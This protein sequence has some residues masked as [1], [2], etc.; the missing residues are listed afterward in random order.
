MRLR[1]AGQVYALCGTPRTL[2]DE[3]LAVDMRRCQRCVAGSTP[4]GCTVHGCWYTQETRNQRS[5]GP[6][7]SACL[8]A[9]RVRVLPSKQVAR[10]RVPLEAPRVVGGT[11][12]RRFAKPRHLMVSRFNSCTTR[13]AA[14]IRA[15]C[16]RQWTRWRWA[17]RVVA[18]NGPQ[19]ASNTGP[20]AR[21]R[22]RVLHCPPC[23][24]R[25]RQGH[26]PCKR[27]NAGPLPV[28]GPYAL[29]LGVEA[30]G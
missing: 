25:P 27:E 18:R 4:A 3:V 11:V 24:C 7:S 9:R 1:A 28:A 2:A 13:R 21:L 19:P 15:R 16:A 26:P 6:K 30:P 20:T 17:T 14:S 22:V 29:V 23:Q 5:D 10:V 12:T 8:C